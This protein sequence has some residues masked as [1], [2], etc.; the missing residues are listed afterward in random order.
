M[1]NMKLRWKN[2]YFL[3]QV[4]LA[5]FTPIFAYFH[6]NIQSLTSLGDFGTI[7]LKSI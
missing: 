3:V 7:L 2:P 1:I 4:V 5:I 6:T